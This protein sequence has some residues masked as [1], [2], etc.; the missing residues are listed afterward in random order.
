MPEPTFRYPDDPGTYARTC[1]RCGLDEGLGAM[2]LCHRCDPP[3]PW[4][5]HLLRIVDERALL[6]RVLRR[7]KSE[8]ASLDAWLGG[9][10]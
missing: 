2:R 5:A 3:A 10:P 7:V 8:L 6:L 9:Q 1:L 4:W